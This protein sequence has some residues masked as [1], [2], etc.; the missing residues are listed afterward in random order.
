MHSP[1]SL[2]LSFPSLLPSPP[3]FLPPALPPA[4][5]HP[6]LS[7]LPSS[8]THPHTLNLLFLFYSFPF[9]F[10]IFLHNGARKKGGVWKSYSQN[11]SDCVS[12]GTLFPPPS[13]RGGA[14]GNP[15]H[16]I[17]DAIGRALHQVRR[18]CVQYAFLFFYF[19]CLHAHAEHLT[20]HVQKNALFDTMHDPR[21]LNPKP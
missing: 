16:W 9:S 8:V 4:L 7:S 18:T 2:F 21:C 6:T 1:P 3:P 5:P 12:S 19:V 13:A 10:F 20:S 14:F 15:I 17:A 11:S